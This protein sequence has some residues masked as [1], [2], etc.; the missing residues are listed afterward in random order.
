MTEMT[1]RE[2]LAA[3]LKRMADLILAYPEVPMR[4][5]F[6]NITA[7]IRL[8]LFSYDDETHGEVKNTLATLARNIKKHAKVEKKFSDF[9]FE[10]VIKPR[11]DSRVTLKLT[12]HRDAVCTKKVVGTKVIPAL[13]SRV[14]DVVEW[15]CEPLL[16]DNP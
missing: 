10:L 1:E 11:E 13:P 6:S 5:G 9:D 7:S 8:Y 12:A 15:E 2:L 16:K 3:D 4:Q 14:V